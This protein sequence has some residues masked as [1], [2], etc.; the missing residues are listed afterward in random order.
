MPAHGY[1]EEID[2]AAILA[3]KWLVDVSPEVNL[4]ERVTHTPPPST[5]KAA[6]SGFETQSP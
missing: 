1:V 2:L 5:N 6:H 4:M 3:T